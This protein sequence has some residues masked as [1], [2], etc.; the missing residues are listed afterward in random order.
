MG[1]LVERR[2]LDQAG[3]NQG[4]GVNGPEGT[5]TA[6][7]LEFVPERRSCSSVTDFEN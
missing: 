5:G 1:V 7:R 6:F 3:R 4:R 2:T